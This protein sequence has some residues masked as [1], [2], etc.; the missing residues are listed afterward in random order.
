[1]TGKYRIATVWIASVLLLT[2]F[3]VLAVNRWPQV[4]ASRDLRAEQF[5]TH[6]MRDAPANAIIFAQ[7][8]Q[9]IF[10][11]WYFHF[12]LKKRTD[13]TVIATDLLHFEWYASALRSHYP[14]VNWPKDTLWVENIT[15]ANRTRP[16]CQ[17]SYYETEIFDCQSI[18]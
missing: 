3:V 18:P 10:S 15:P 5:G 16:I 7:S 17:V 6:I 13:L 11:L 9:A 14:K 1:L 12:A 2:W 8:D 4:D